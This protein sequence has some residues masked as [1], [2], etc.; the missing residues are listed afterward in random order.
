MV[1]GLQKTSTLPTIRTLLWRVTTLAIILICLSACIQESTP[2]V[3]P[4][5]T[6]SATA[7]ETPTIIWFPASPTPSPIPTKILTPTPE[8]RL[9]VGEIILL[10]D[11][12]EEKNWTLTAV[13]SGQ[14]A[15][16][17]NE[18]SI[19]IVEPKVLLYSVRQEPLFSDFYVEITASPSLCVGLDE[20]GLLLRYAS[21]ADFYRFSLSCDG[22]VRLDRVVGGVAASPQP[23]ISSANVPNGAPSSARLGVWAF[24]DE[25]N[26]FIN[27]EYQFSIRDSM[28]NS[29][30]LGVFARSTGDNAV[31]VSFSN[32][33]VRQ[34]NP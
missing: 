27:D 19:A 10:D 8:R 21:P 3:T 4:T 32:L 25:M 13:D 16:G 18:L 11:F 22:Q 24:G 29:G 33:V 31:S 15:L 2:I 12:N 23:W 9:D 1:P 20:Y 34:I 7:S 26:F 28:L 5:E 14:T 6:P 30:L 17:I